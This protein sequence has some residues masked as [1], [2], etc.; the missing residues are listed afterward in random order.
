[1]NQV[2]PSSGN[3]KSYTMSQMLDGKVSE[4]VMPEMY[5]GTKIIHILPE[6]S[7]FF[8]MTLNRALQRSLVLQLEALEN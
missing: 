3:N 4:H 5:R 7:V 8:G 2:L 6:L 1:M